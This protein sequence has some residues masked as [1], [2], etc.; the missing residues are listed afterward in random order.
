[1]YKQNDIRLSGG[2]YLTNLDN[3]HCCV[4]KNFADNFIIKVDLH[5]TPVSS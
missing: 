5:H 4:D 2:G 1:M 3:V